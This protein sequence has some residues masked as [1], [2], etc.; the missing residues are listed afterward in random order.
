M[1]DSKRNNKFIA[2]GLA[3][4][5]SQ[6]PN[7]AAAEV[8][9]SER[10]MITAAEMIELQRSRSEKQEISDF[11][12]RTEVQKALVSHG[13]SPEEAKMR[14]ASL[15]PEEV[16]DLS[17]HINEARAGG[18]ILTT[19]LLILLIVFLIERV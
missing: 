18:D 1:K 3:I 10:K 14:L 16:R 9:Q 15:S 12:Q 2:L 11:L 19:I 17:G 6:A 13:V 5:V 4:L 8:K 7:V